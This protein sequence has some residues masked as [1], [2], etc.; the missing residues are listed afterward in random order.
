MLLTTFAVD[1]VEDRMQALENET[2]NI[3]AAAK[4]DEAPLTL[5]PSRLLMPSLKLCLALMLICEVE[6]L[7]HADQSLSDYFFKV[8]D[9]PVLV[10]SLGLL[11]IFRVLKRPAGEARRFGLLDNAYT[12]AALCLMMFVVAA[13]GW[14][15]VFARHPLSLDEFWATFD[16]AIFKQG[17]LAAPISPANRPYALA[18]QPVWRLASQGDTVWASS[19]LPVN[20]AVRGLLG[21][22]GLDGCAGGFWI[23]AGAAAM[24]GVARRLWPQRRDAALVALLLVATSSQVLVTAM[25]PYA[26][27]GHFA[28]NMIWLLLFLQRK[29]W[30]LPAALAVGAAACGLHQLIFHLLFV[31]PFI[32]ELWLGRRFRAAAFLTLGYAAVSLFW[33]SYWAWMLPAVG[34]A[35]P[36]SHDVGASGFVQHVIELLQDFSPG[37]AALMAENLVRFIAWQNPLFLPLLL[38]GG[39]AALRTSGPLRPLLLGTGLTLAAV[40]VVMAYQGHG[41]GYRYLAGH[42]GGLALIAAGAW[43]ALTAETPATGAWRGASTVLLVSCAVS[44]FVLLPIHALQAHAFE[45]PYARAEAAIYASRA[46][47]VLVDGTG[48]SFGQDLVQNDPFLRRRPQVM[49]LPALTPPLLHQLCLTHSWAL[50]GDREARAAG[51]SPAPDAPGPETQAARA[52]LAHDPACR[53]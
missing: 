33:M 36:A 51:L 34:A 14:P 22:I 25:T 21:R 10:I 1:A 23:V 30:S 12:P 48:L 4:P 13:V 28:L 9:A 16:A 32:A 6:V 15:L 17:V 44:V 38:A 24:Y 49:L 37:A 3:G 2:G 18:L 8:Q 40:F 47:V 42:L 52:V 31:A 5:L 27:S 50:F 29:W 20:A 26:M 11:L 19:Y 35:A 7:T 39:G 43:V 45:H 53:R 46:D 41:W